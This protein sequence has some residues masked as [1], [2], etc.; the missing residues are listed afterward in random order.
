M[1]K[2]QFSSFLEKLSESL[3][4]PSSRYEEAEEHY[5]AVGNWL[6][7]AGSELVS[8]EPE[9][10]PQG[11]FRLGTAIK[12][13]SEADE[14][15]IDLVCE[16]RLNKKQVSQ[17]QLKHM[18]GDRLKAHDTYRKMLG[19][20]EGRR[21]WTLNYADGAQFHMDILPAIPD[22]EKYKV[23]LTEHKVPIGLAEHAICIT[24]NTN[25]NFDT[26]DDSWPRSNP[27]GYAEWFKNRMIVRFE[28][29]LR[30]LAAAMEA[31]VEEVPEY[32]VKTPLQQ[33]VQILKRHR[34]MVFCDDKDDKPISVIITTLAAHAYN[35][36]EDLLDALTKIVNG[37]SAHIS[38]HA[39]ASWVPNPVNPM[40]NF[41]DKWQEHPAREVKFRG[42][43]RQV[44][45]DFAR[46]LEQG[47]LRAVGG[48]FETRFGVSAVNEALGMV[49]ALSS[50]RAMISKTE[51]PH[52]EIRNPNK[53]WGRRD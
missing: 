32:R 53:P 4:V 51:A 30:V 40:E 21:C 22:E 11:S 48:A 13:L 16:L 35:N 17:K 20:E 33:V 12:P 19:K 2:S 45:D 52:V 27:R 50:P 5:K 43:L 8:Y 41:A 44:Q 28:S 42:W 39:G 14:Y 25:L 10:Y 46:A 23:M 47:E 7:D 24:D 34:D 31:S 38:T 9:I 29:R 15:D 26:I 6:G 36:E 1:N 49:G 37:M 3:E 18:I